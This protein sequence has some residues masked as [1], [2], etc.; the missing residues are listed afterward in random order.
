MC[1]TLPLLSFPGGLGQNTPEK[2]LLPLVLENKRTNESFGLRLRLTTRLR[3]TSPQDL[4][5]SGTC[6]S[7]VKTHTSQCKS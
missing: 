7:H 5:G 2:T 6:G 3:L 1:L 4:A